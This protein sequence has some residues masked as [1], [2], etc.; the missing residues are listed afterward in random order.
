MHSSTSSSKNRPNIRIQ[1]RRGSECAVNLQRARPFRVRS[2]ASA[3]RLH[4]LLRDGMSRMAKIML[5]EPRSM[6]GDLH[7]TLWSSTLQPASL[8]AHVSHFNNSDV[9]HAE[10]HDED[11]SDPTP[12]TP[13]LPSPARAGSKE[14][15]GAVRIWDGRPQP[16]VFEQGAE[17]C[18]RSARGGSARVPER[19]RP[20]RGRRRGCRSGRMSRHCVCAVAGVVQGGVGRLVR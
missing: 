10:A 8:A 9:E 7:S 17:G 20:Y 14:C 3:Q 2:A 19:G 5:Q 12:P 11:S 6:S 18:D 13:S 4:F 16:A 15:G 1:Q